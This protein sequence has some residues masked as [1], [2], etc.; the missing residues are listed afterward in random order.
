M[1]R[2]EVDCGRW[3]G[4]VR[5]RQDGGSFAQRCAD[6][7]WPHITPK[8]PQYAK[9]ADPIGLFELENMLLMLCHYLWLFD[10]HNRAESPSSFKYFLFYLALEYRLC[11]VFIH[12]FIFSFFF[13][14]TTQYL[15]FLDLLHF[16]LMLL[17]KRHM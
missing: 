8:C 15:Q 1:W 2:S 13:L 17:E 4:G 3:K 11:P 5:G 16:F 10:D 12:V 7:G 9:A 6:L 14:L